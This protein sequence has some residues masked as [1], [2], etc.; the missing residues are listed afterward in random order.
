MQQPSRA[1]I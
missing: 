1:G